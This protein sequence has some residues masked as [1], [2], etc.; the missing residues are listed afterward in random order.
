LAVALAKNCQL[1]VG[2]LDAD[3]YGPSVPMMMKIDRKPDIT[4]G[5]AL[6]F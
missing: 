4:E 6:I 1:K 3:V 2:L 5:N